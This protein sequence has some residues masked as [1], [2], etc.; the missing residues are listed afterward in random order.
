MVEIGSQYMQNAALSDCRSFGSSRFPAGR[1]PKISIGITVDKCS[2]TGPG[3]GMESAGALSTGG[4]TLSCKGAEETTKSGNV[5]T[6][7]RNKSDNFENQ[8]PSVCFS[9]RSDKNGCIKTP[10][11]ATVKLFTKSGSLL[12]SEDDTHRNLDPV[13]NGMIREKGGNAERVEETAFPTMRET[14]LG[15]KRNTRE[16][17]EQSV[18]F[19]EKKVIAV[20]YG[21]RENGGDVERTNKVAFSTRQLVGKENGRDLEK[22]TKCNNE[23]LKMKLWEILGTAASENKHTESSPNIMDHKESLDTNQTRGNQREKV[24]RTKPNLTNIDGNKE[25]FDTNRNKE[26]KKGKIS[27]G[28]PISRDLEENKRNLNKQQGREFRKANKGKAARAKQNS[29]TIETDSESPNKVTRRPVT[30]S[31]ARK[32]APPK[33]IQKLQSDVSCAKK[34]LSCSDSDFRLKPEKENTFI[35]DEV[36]G[37]AGSLCHTSSGN[38]NI[39]AEKFNDLKKAKNQSPKIQFPQ[40]IQ[41]KNLQSCFREQTS[42]SPDKPSK[43]SK[44]KGNSSVPHQEKKQSLQ[45]VDGNLSVNFL[46]QRTGQLNIGKPMWA[47][48]SETRE[49]TDSPLSD[50]KIHSWGHENS[51]PEPK[52]D[53]LRDDVVSG[54]METHSRLSDDF[55]SPTLATDAT[56]SPDVP[57]D[58]VMPSPVA[59]RCCKSIPKSYCLKDLSD[60]IPGSCQQGAETGSSDNTGE[61]HNPGDV[62]SPLLKGETQKRKFF[63]FPRV[64][65][66]TESEADALT[67]QGFGLA[68][69]WSPCT[70]S[71]NKSPPSCRQTKRLR[72]LNI[73]KPIKANLPS[74]SLIGTSRTEELDGSEILEQYPEG[75]LARCFAQLALV[76]GRFKRRMMSQTS[77]RSSEILSAAGDKVRQQLQNVE[78]QILADVGKFNNIGKSKHK[79]LES[80]FREHQER[81]KLIHDKFKEEV[82]LHLLDCRTTLEELQACNMELK[83][84]SDRQKASHKKLLQEVGVA[85]EAQI[86]DAELSVAAIRKDARKKMNVLERA[87]KEWM[88]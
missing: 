79:R 56:A 26:C 43:Q 61:S 13:S 15:D 72:S 57:H 6:L 37:K 12:H 18:K 24:S 17:P 59:A 87:F 48:T 65:Q 7:E 63:L 86:H 22:M 74:P 55:H 41:E 38:S 28:K 69:K 31:L 14:S 20:D 76:L 78:S 58:E 62:E 84:T 47:H 16:E 40:Y 32:Q 1:F 60:F 11:A 36:E 33:R 10:A 80:R 30:R 5:W 21:K 64:E 35:F 9:T 29:D 68:Y 75:S 2:K 71:P 34:P 4:L 88:D 53:F 85:M 45:T 73:V 8:G 27:K 66:D 42:P 67:S 3:V 50:M 19:S 23:A 46:S 51:L 52:S 82:N 70:E 44:G 77:K 39:S 49:N 25:N 54:S 83:E 81:I